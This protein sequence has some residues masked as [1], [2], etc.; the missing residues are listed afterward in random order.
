MM[1]NAQKLAAR[2]SPFFERPLRKAGAGLQYRRLCPP[3]HRGWVG[4]VIAWQGGQPGL[5]TF[6]GGENYQ[7]GS[8]VKPPLPA[9]SAGLPQ[10]RFC[11]YRVRPTG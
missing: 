10:V 3:A 9:S 7:P 5:H 4:A 8:P 11:S 1:R 2:V 6:P